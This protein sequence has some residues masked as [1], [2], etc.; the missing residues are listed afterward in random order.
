MRRETFE[1]LLFLEISW[2]ASFSL[3][4]GG[5]NVLRLTLDTPGG[6]PREGGSGSRRAAG[7]G[8]AAEDV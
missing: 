2:F 1:I 5:V 3:L 7:G 6:C 4:E 8:N